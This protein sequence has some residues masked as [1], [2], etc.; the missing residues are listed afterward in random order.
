L[1]FVV[2]I[3]GVFFCERKAITLVVVS[4]ASK[5]TGMNQ[6]FQNTDFATMCVEILG[7]EIEIESGW[8]KDSFCC[9]MLLLFEHCFYVHHGGDFS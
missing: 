9:L 1:L 3:V 7:R 5:R 4:S 8:L 2:L 6:K